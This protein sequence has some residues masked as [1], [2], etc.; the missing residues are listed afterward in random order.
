MNCYHKIESHGKYMIS[1]TCRKKDLN[2]S[3]WFEDRL[4]KLAKK[5]Y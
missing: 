1:L 5:Y 3:S 2:A 4:H